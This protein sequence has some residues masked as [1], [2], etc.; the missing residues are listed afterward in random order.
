VPRA[1]KTRASIDSNGVYVCWHSF[2]CDLPDGRQINIGQGQK[3]RGDS[4]A[5]SQCS[6]YFVADGA[7]IEDVDAHRK[8]VFPDGHP[9]TWL[10]LLIEGCR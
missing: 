2:A 6:Q 3:L 9:A 10:P 7:S 1:A 5:V 4:P 8:E